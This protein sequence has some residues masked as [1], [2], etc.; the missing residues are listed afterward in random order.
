M[1]SSL[2]DIKMFENYSQSDVPIVKVEA[3]KVTF[4]SQGRIVHAVNDVTF[5]LKRGETL[6]LVGESGCGKSVTAMSIMRLLPHPPASLDYGRILFEGQDILSLSDRDMRS[7]RGDRMAMIFQSPITSLNPLLSIGR[8]ITEG[9]EKHC[10]LSR[11]AATQRAMDFLKRVRIPDPKRTLRQ[12]PHE[13][14][15]GMCQRI[16]I[17]VA[18]STNPDV[19][20]ADEPTTALDVTIQ[21]QILNIINELQIGSNTAMLLIT[22]DLGVVAEVAD[23]V[24]IMYAGAIAEIA[25]VNELF[26]RPSHPYTIGLMRSMPRLQSR[27]SSGQQRKRLHE[28]KGLVPNMIHDLAGCAFAPR[29][30]WVRDRCHLET[31]NLSPIQQ[32]HLVACWEAQKLMES[33]HA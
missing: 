31:P 22:H 10:G 33:I 32:D 13:L 25:D 7:L 24:L 30:D 8:Q 12:Y 21:A 16:M 18:L 14:S 20:I 17:A 29:C 28:I 4:R 19:L 9:L 5:D 26:S 1:S 23:R 3:L 2:N 6:C 15:G 27:E 11:R